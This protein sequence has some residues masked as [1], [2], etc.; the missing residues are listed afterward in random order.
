MGS[1]KYLEDEF[2]FPKEIDFVQ[3]LFT[4]SPCFATIQHNITNDGVIWCH[5]NF[6]NWCHNISL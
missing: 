3:G 5:S 6:T 2:F 1:S 4:E